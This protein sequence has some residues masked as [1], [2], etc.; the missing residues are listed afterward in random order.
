MTYSVHIQGVHGEVIGVQV[1]GLE[2]LLHGDLLAVELVHDALGVHA[3]RPFDEAQQVLLV[4]AGRGVDVGVHLER[5]WE[6][7]RERMPEVMGFS[8]VVITLLG[9]KRLLETHKVNGRQKSEDD[10]SAGNTD[11]K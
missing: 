2:E 6:G 10:N 5:P 11:Y 3:V 8:W 1:E 4:H 9:N 7:V